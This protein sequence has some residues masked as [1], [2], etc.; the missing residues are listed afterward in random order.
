MLLSRISLAALRTFAEV[1]KQRSLS[2]AAEQL[3]I[4][5][6]AV[7]HQMKLLEQ[8]L[9]ISLFARRSRGIELTEAGHVLAEYAGGA[10]Q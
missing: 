1:A 3:C 8:Q 9:D 6:S 4:S 5:Q 7:S 10:M 2:R